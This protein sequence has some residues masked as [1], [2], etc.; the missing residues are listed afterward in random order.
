MAERGDNDDPL[1]DKL[2]SLMQ[3]G[4]APQ[5]HNPPP[6]LTDT[7]PDAGESAIPTLTDAVNAPLA[8]QKPA[9]DETEDPRE[10]IAS[11]LLALIDE[12]MEKLSREIGGH[13]PRLAL[14]HRTL[15]FAV[16]E[17]VRLRWEEN[18]GP[19]EGTVEGE[20]SDAGR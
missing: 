3:R 12:E 19:E 4:H 13:G 10:L 9:E 2:D 20:D 6:R 15:R 7:V 1:L 5:S 11:R 8:G 18:P 16:P 17:L 14:L